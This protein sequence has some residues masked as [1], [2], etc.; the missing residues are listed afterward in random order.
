MATA[1]GKQYQMDTKF[2]SDKLT[3]VQEVVLT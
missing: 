3:T 2:V 1:L